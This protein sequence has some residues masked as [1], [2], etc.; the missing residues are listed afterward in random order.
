MQTKVVIDD[1]VVVVALGS[2]GG[3]QPCQHWRLTVQ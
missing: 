2:A 1:V 3:R